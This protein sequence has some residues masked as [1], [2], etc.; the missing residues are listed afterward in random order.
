MESA[1]K[2][3]LQEFQDKD[4]HLGSQQK[5]KISFDNQMLE[6]SKQGLSPEQPA[7]RHDPPVPALEVETDVGTWQNVQMS[8]NPIVELMQTLHDRMSLFRA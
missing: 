6:F 4:Y 5:S 2:T 1:L 8:T 3:K 7:D